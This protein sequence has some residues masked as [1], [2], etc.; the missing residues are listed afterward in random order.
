LTPDTERLARKVA[1]EAGETIT[2]AI[3]RA[4]EERLLRMTG[5]AMPGRL[6]DEIM[7]IGERCAALPD[8][9]ERSADEIIGY[10]PDGTPR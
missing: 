10:G 7:K 9:D 6:V 8:L 4:L 1:D 2:Q 3:T 5:K